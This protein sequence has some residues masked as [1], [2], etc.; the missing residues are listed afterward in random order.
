MRSLKYFAAPWAAVLF[1][2]IA[3]FITGNAGFSAYD[4][5]DLE[6]KKQNLNLDRLA[7]LHDALDA[8]RENLRSDPETIAQEAVNIGYGR[9][10]ES[11]IRIT[12]FNGRTKQQLQAGEMVWAREPDAVQD[13]TLKMYAIGICIIVLGA[14]GVADILRFIRDA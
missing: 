14:M 9:E 7:K 13:E 3:S 8:E 2:A 4:Q 11:Y 5:L 6:R 12:G 1:Y 10:G